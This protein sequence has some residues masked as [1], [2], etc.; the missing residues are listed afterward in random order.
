MIKI[1]K[2][3]YFCIIAFIT[4]FVTISIVAVIAKKYTDY[5]T[6]YTQIKLIDNAPTSLR[7]KP[8]NNGGVQ[9]DHQDKNVFQILEK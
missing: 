6:Q 4:A 8:E 7:H 5:P 1:S 3:Q 2:Y 9:F